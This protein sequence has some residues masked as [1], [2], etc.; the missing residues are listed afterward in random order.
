MKNIFYTFCTILSIVWASFTNTNAARP[1]PS[2]L[3]ERSTL[4][5]LREFLA[6]N[7]KNFQDVH[8]Y[9]EYIKQ[10]RLRCVSEQPG[11]LPATLIVG[12]LRGGG[13]M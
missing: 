5:P 9:F 11:L 12:S 2:A 13:N 10:E 6:A 3:R 1:A 7:G 8:A 4:L